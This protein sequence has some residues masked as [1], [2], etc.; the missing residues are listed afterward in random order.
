[1]NDIRR[2]LLW[3]VFLMSLA[4][5]WDAWNRHNGQ[6]TLFGVPVTTEAAPAASGCPRVCRPRWLLLAPMPSRPSRPWLRPTRR[7]RGNASSYAPMC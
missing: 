7:R 4:M 1:M 3:I 6:P 2:T 5:L